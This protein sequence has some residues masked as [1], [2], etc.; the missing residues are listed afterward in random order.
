MLVQGAFSRITCKLHMRN[1]RAGFF[2]LGGV[3]FNLVNV[4]GIV[5]NTV[6]SKGGRGYW[7][8]ASW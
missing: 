3:P 7:L 5:M 8:V 1:N 2:L 4:V 6:R